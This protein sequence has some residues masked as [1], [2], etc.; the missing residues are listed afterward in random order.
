MNRSIPPIPFLTSKKV[1]SLI[2]WVAIVAFLVGC[3]TKGIEPD[4]SR[5][6]GREKLSTS[7]IP[8]YPEVGKDYM[9]GTSYSDMDVNPNNPNQIVSL[10]AVWSDELSTEPL[11]MGI[12]MLDLSTGEE[13]WLAEGTHWFNTTWGKQG[14]I[15]AESSFDK[16]LYLVRP[17][18]DSLHRC[19]DPALGSYHNPSWIADGTEL[20]SKGTSGERISRVG[21]TD[22]SGQLKREFLLSNGNIPGTKIGQYADW[23]SDSLIVSWE[24]ID[25]WALTI[26]SYPDLQLVK[27]IEVIEPGSH[28]VILHQEWLP[29]TDEIYWLKEG[30]LY[31]TNYVTEETRAIWQDCDQPVTQFSIMPNGKKI[32]CLVPESEIREDYGGLNQAS[33]HLYMLDLEAGMMDRIR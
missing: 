18:G 8:D 22:I 31:S 28:G 27:E 26:L 16:Q 5:N 10:K 21:I 13:I 14:W 29:G 11:K 19:S 32:L 1:I 20:L 25:R 9:M 12:V 23:R 30:F 7:Y 33:F 3:K 15:V 6:R 24:A 17:N 4:C 2:G